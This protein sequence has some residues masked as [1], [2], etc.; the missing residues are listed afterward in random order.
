MAKAAVEVKQDVL[1]KVIADLEAA[2]TFPNLN[3]L[4]NEAAKKYNETP[5]V[6][7][8]I[9]FSVVYQRV[10][11]WKLE[12]K[13]QPGKRRN[14]GT[15]E[16]TSETETDTIDVAPKLTVQFSDKLRVVKQDRFNI[17]IERK[18]ND[19]WKQQGFYGSFATALTSLLDVSV[20]GGVMSPKDLMAAW[21]ANT[22]KIID[23]V[24][25]ATSM[26]EA[27]APVT[28]AE[29]PDEGEEAS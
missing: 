29:E 12:V 14:K 8:Q 13:T 27:P 3:T 5:G 22:Q 7:A 17:V 1:T 19:A 15:G 18:I 21:E 2:K 26:K 23:A 20:S 16:V 11:A 4:W 24:R 6:P 9:T 28:P 25:N 10:K